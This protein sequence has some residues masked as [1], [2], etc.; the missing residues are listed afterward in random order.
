MPSTV[1][2]LL[3]GLL[4]TGRKTLI[5]GSRLDNNARHILTPLAKDLT[6]LQKE[7]DVHILGLISALHYDYPSSTFFL[8]PAFTNSVSHDMA[9]AFQMNWTLHEDEEKKK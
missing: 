3:S 4:Q 8:F 5:I 7:T 1:L 9:L 2:V 6:Q